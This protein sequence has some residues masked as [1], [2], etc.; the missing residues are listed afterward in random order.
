[1]KNKN[2]KICSININGLNNKL[3]AI[4]NLMED[5]KIDIMCIYLNMYAFESFGK[6]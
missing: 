3:N 4:H 2:I 5:N 1:M 6:K